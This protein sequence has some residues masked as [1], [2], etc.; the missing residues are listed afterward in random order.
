VLNSKLLS[1]PF[2][3]LGMPIGANPRKVST[4]D[5]IVAKF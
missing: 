2:V 4:W 5:P 3:Y 1:L